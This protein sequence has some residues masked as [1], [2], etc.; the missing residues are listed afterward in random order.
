MLRLTR[1]IAWSS[2]ACKFDT[3]SRGSRVG[4]AAEDVVRNGCGEQ[5]EIQTGQVD[6]SGGHGAHGHDGRLNSEQRLRKSAMKS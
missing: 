6:P 5:S 3:S 2:C 4:Y 1:H